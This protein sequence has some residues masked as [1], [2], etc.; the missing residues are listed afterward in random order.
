MVRFLLWNRAA[1]HKNHRY[2]A[3]A[4]TKSKFSSEKMINKVVRLI[5]T[6]KKRIKTQ[7]SILLGHFPINLCFYQLKNIPRT[8]WTKVLHWI[9]KSRQ[10]LLQIFQGQATKYQSKDKYQLNMSQNLKEN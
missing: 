10:R 9:K 4:L 6:L 2:K 7:K 8:F 5:K 3:K 1:N